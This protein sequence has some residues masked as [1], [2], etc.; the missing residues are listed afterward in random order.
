MTAPLR[1]LT[2]KN[3][4]F[5]WQSRHQQAFNKLQASLTEDAVLSYVHLSKETELIVHALPT[6]LAAIL[7]QRKSGNDHANVVAYGSRALTNVE[8]RYSQ[9]EREA[10]AIVFGCEH[11]RLF[12]Y[13]TISHCT[14]ITSHW[15]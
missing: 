11:F 8:Q 9:T 3:I 13:G 1:E 4:P 12:L 6:G 14:Q 10:L 15:N 5:E 2:K 7:L